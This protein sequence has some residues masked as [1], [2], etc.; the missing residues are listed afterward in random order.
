[1][2]EETECAKYDFY[3]P[4]GLITNVHDFE[5]VR[6]SVSQ[7][8]RF[9]TR[10]N[11]GH[12]RLSFNGGPADTLFRGE[13]VALMWDP[14]C[15]PDR[16]VP[17]NRKRCFLRGGSSD[18]PSFSS[19]LDKHLLNA[20]VNVREATK[21]PLGPMT[22]AHHPPWTNTVFAEKDIVVVREHLYDLIRDA[23]AASSPTE[24]DAASPQH[25]NAYCMSSPKESDAA[26]PKY[27]EA[28]CLKAISKNRLH[29]CLLLAFVQ[30]KNIDWNAMAIKHYIVPANSSSS[31]YQDSQIGLIVGS[32]LAWLTQSSSTIAVERQR[33]ICRRATHA[34]HA[35]TWQADRPSLWS[36]LRR[37]GGKLFTRGNTYGRRNHTSGQ[38]AARRGEIPL[39]TS[40]TAVTKVTFLSRWASLRWNLTDFD[41]FLFDD[42]LLVEGVCDR[43]WAEM[44]PVGY[45][46]FVKTG[47]QLQQRLRFVASEGPVGDV[48]RLCRRGNRVS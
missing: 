16:A 6:S 42:D 38:L 25:A 37:S 27:W 29:R 17:P 36:H 39:C 24:S 4:E 30:A 33:E 46:M 21:E 23:Q 44:L 22:A 19:K 34:G 1:M 26:S 40:G 14:P 5:R 13:G 3:Y 8:N 7:S 35:D 11:A 41:L 28:Y 31:V 48:G 47:C 20:W 12:Y 10:L 2:G 43:T 45:I 32:L 15:V 18:R 9:N